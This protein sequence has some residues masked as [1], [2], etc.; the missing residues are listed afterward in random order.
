[1]IEAMGLGS[2]QN[3]RL[4]REEDVYLGCVINRAFPY[5]L[6]QLVL[7]LFMEIDHKDVDTAS[8]GPGSHRRNF[9]HFQTNQRAPIAKVSD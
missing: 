9:I 1:V 6:R 2:L 8:P 3:A 5:D 7:V 4:P